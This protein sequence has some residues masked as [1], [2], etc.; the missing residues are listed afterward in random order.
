MSRNEFSC[1]CNVIHQD[2][3]EEVLQKMP[4]EDIFNRDQKQLHLLKIC[5]HY[6]HSL[7]FLT[8]SHLQLA[9]GMMLER[10]QVILNLTETHKTVKN[11]N[12]LFSSL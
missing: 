2:A 1:D 10:N 9:W 12:K 11:I 8:L 4:N 7:H 5:L 3:V 6:L